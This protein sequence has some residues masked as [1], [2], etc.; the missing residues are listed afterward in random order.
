VTGAV[1][2]AAAALFVSRSTRLAGTVLATILM[3][4]AAGTVLVHGEYAHAI[5]PLIV[6]IFSVLVGATTMRPRLPA[7]SSVFVTGRGLL[8]SLA[9]QISRVLPGHSR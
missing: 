6:M 9:E 2:F 1:E 4:G 5:A 3:C 8:R 7:A